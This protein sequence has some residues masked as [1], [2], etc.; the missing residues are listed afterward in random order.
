MTFFFGQFTNC[1]DFDLDLPSLKSDSDLELPI[2]ESDLDLDLPS[3]SSDLDLDRRRTD[4]DVLMVV[5][6]IESSIK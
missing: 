1:Q 4:G 6:V 2:L 5:K 3:L